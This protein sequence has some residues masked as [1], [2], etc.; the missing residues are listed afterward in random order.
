M[1]INEAISRS[2]SHNE[3][4]RINVADKTEAKSIIAAAKEIAAAAGLDYDYTDDNDGYDMW[5]CKPGSD[6]MTWRVKLVLVNAN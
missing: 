4:A 2:E 1:N 5:A 3:I 6:D